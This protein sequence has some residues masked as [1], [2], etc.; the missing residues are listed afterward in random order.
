MTEYPPGPPPGSY[1]PPPAGGYPPPPP[2][3]GGYYPPSPAAGTNGMAIASLVCSLIGWLCGLGPIL[4]VIFGFVA[5]NQ[6]KQSGQEGRG[7][8][9]AGIVI[10][11]ATIVIG[12]IVFIVLM[13]VGAH[14]PST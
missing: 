6:I 3:G 11:I 1:P 8:A 5:L 9:L 13:V 14:Q 2:P 4:G 7:L 10:S 12:A